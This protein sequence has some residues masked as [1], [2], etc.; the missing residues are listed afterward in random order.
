MIC[1]E[2]FLNKHANTFVFPSRH[3]EAQSAAVFGDPDGPREDRLDRAPAEIAFVNAATFQGLPIPAREEVVEGLIPRRAV[4]ILGG[5]GG[6]GKSLL[7]LQLAVSLQT[8]INWCGRVVF[9]RG[10]AIFLT[11]EDEIAEV[12][13]RLH[14]IVREQSTDFDEL[15][16][17]HL[18]SLAGEDALLGELGSSRTTIVP[19]ELYRKLDAAIARIKPRMVVLDTLS[20][21]FG[22]DEIN[23]V[24]ARQFIG[25]LR[26]LAIRHDTTVL[27]LA[28]PSLT[29]INSGTGTSG[30][31][32]WSNSA[33]SRLYF[34]RIKAGGDNEDDPDARILTCKK[35]NYGPTGLGI[36]MRWQ[37]GCLCPAT[38]DE[39]RLSVGYRGQG[40]E[41]VPEPFGGIYG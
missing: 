4:T 41:G 29:G 24:Q 13:R 31:T 32:G 6:T 9:E 21:L 2:S 3:D 15:A 38:R 18:L 40:A 37:R 17:L 22:G 20:D 5:D 27:L 25:L 36:K 14:D 12:H 1:P 7:A 16:G 26:A 28:H 35:S 11:A 23:R 30:S 39:R 19:T 33:R 10:P 8:S 34:S